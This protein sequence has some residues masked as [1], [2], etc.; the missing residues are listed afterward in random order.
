MTFLDSFT[1]KMLPTPSERLVDALVRL[2]ALRATS[3][4]RIDTASVSEATKANARGVVERSYEHV[5]RLCPQIFAMFD[6]S[7]S[8]VRH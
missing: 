8:E 1:S 7:G 6:T 5:A 4:G 3:H 2:E